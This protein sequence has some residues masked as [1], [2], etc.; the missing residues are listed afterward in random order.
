[1]IGYNV[2]KGL[3]EREMN[4]KSLPLILILPTLILI[5]AACSSG[6]AEADI[7]ATLQARLTATAR[8]EPTV[9]PAPTLVPTA[10]PVPPPPTATTSPQGFQD[11]LAKI[12]KD[13][14]PAPTPTSI[15]PTVTP[16]PTATPNPT[17][18]PTPTPRPYVTLP[19]APT[20]IVA[21]VGDTRATITWNAPSDD[22]GSEITEY[23]IHASPGGSGAWYPWYEWSA[24]GFTEEVTGLTNGISYTFTVN[25]TN[26]VGHGQES[27]PSNSVIPGGVPGN[28]KNVVATAGNGQATVT[29]DYLDL[30]TYP[31][32]T[33]YT[34]TASPG[35][36]TATKE[37]FHNWST[38]DLVA[39]VT[40]L[41]NGTSYTFTVT[42]TNSI[43]EGFPSSAS[44]AVT[45]T[46]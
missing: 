32:I 18:T 5:L 28:P 44:N 40:G 22:G 45:L 10:T 43:G 36:A 16:T 35:G 26:S 9:A 24:N 38:S 19:G 7:E 13:W 3:R 27:A 23:H 34:V 11:L 30:N 21:T 1:M 29:W 14:T 46:S 37:L 33:S 42:A 4:L 8:P 41:T 15:P 2:S 25:A 12:I 6:P 31:L 17:P 39:T 20:E